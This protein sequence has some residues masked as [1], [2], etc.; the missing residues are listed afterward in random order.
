MVLDTRHVEREQLFAV[1]DA[2]PSDGWE[3]LDGVGAEVFEEAGLAED[4]GCGDAI[5]GC[6]EAG[7][8]AWIGFEDERRDVVLGE[9]K[10]ENKT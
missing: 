3:R 2:P 10:G 1:C 8:E 4:P 9:S 7:V 5:L 6:A